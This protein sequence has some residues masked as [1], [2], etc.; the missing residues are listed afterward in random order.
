MPGLH[1]REV[2]YRLR[3][4]QNDLP[5]MIITAYPGTGEENRDL[6]EKATGFFPKPFDLGEL[7]AA[8]KK[9]VEH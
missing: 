2:F 3:E 5:I 1:G 9:V 8:I 6:K 4:M 7:K